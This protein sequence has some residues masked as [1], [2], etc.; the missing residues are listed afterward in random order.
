MPRSHLEP[1]W[2]METRLTKS[3]FQCL[4]FLFFLTFVSVFAI[5]QF[6]NSSSV[7]CILNFVEKFKVKGLN[8]PFS[9]LGL[10]SFYRCCLRVSL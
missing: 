3:N 7:F 1:V 2:D 6:C 8:A 9:L 4:D 5:K 10:W